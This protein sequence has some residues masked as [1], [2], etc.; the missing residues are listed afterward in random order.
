MIK[1]TDIY[2]NGW[3]RASGFTGKSV[4]VEV[5]DG[6]NRVTFL[7]EGSPQLESAIQEFRDDDFTRRFISEYLYSKRLIT[8]A[9]HK[10]GR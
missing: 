2:L 3:L 8:E 6:R 4:E 5:V 7:Y 9:L 10:E 1:I